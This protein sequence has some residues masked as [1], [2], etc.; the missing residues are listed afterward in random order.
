MDWLDLLAVQGTLKS[1]L[2]HHSSKASIV[3]HST[4]FIVQLSHPYMTTGKRP[5]VGPSLVHRPPGANKPPPVG[6]QLS[7]AL[8]VPPVQASRWSPGVAEQIKVQILQRDLDSRLPTAWPWVCFSAFL[9][10]SFFIC[11]MEIIIVPG[12]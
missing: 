11:K 12:T 4:F 8:G 5:T 7:Y 10:F 6:M 9:C 2:Q 1:R 3:R